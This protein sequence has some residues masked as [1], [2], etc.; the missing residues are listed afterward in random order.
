[1]I[2]VTGDFQNIGIETSFIRLRPVVPELLQKVYFC[3]MAGR[4][5]H[6]ACKGYMGRHGECHSHDGLPR[7]YRVRHL[8]CEVT[9][10]SSAVIAYFPYNFSA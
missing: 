2:F 5:L 10:S 8:I 3:T 7:K 1:V 6:N 4:K 9:I